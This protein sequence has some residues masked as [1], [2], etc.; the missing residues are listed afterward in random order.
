MR[1]FHD[2][3]VRA[4]PQLREIAERYLRHYRGVF[5]PIVAA[6][7]SLEVGGITDSHIRIV[8]NCM[9]QDP[10]VLNMPSPEDR[11]FDA[12]SELPIGRSKSFRGM[13]D[14][15]AAA[16]PLKPERKFSYPL[17]TKW[18]YWYGISIHPHAE[19]IH[20]VNPESTMM[21]YTSP[22][23]RRKNVPNRAREGAECELYWLCKS[24]MYQMPSPI[25]HKI[26]LLLV[27]EVTELLE[28]GMTVTLPERRWRVC[29]RCE[30]LSNRN[31]L[32]AT[33]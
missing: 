10:N 22:G 23:M 31:A 3:D 16:V 14:E 17:K 11:T 28:R 8:L 2:G 7:R 9:L 1:K 29:S 18:K 4:D 32:Q 24:S 26:R 15:I 27:D 5:D 19:L 20:E 25:E 12:G 21:Y 30:F 6:Q 33:T 13:L